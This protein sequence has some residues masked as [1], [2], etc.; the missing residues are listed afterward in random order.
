MIKNMNN[1]PPPLMV[2]FAVTRAC[3]LKCKH[4][5]S[6]ATEVPAP[7]ELST[8]EAKSLIADLAELRTKRIIFDGGE[9]TL[10]P[11]L[12]ELISHARQV[13]L[14]PSLGTNAT[15]LDRDYAEHLKGSGL[16]SLSVSLDGA[17]P[18]THDDFRGVPG[19]FA[20]TLRGIEQ[21]K[22]VGLPF[23]IGMVAHHHNLSELEDVARLAHELG[24]FTMEI[25]EFMPV[26][27]GR[28]HPEYLLTD[29]Q[30]QELVE[31]VIE[32]QRQEDKPF[33]ELNAIPQWIVRAQQIVPEA[34]LRKFRRSCCIA[35][36]AYATVLYN[37]RVQP[38]MLLPLEVGNVRERKFSELWQNAGIFKSLRDTSRLQGR[39]GRCAHRESC[40]GAR[41]RAY[42]QTGDPLAEDPACWLF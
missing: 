22:A 39:C 33:Y 34:E 3:N 32:L 30:R 5:Y 14:L 20:E 42:A 23:Q 40:R 10:R 15:L 19:T 38:C 8:A 31:R 24:A 1:W 29:A 25:F 26:G 2:N 36:T 12:F 37:G 28:E 11:D 6:E 21:L 7:D 41:C 35:G 13:G 18:E 4:C 27:R 17:K 9:P 16:V